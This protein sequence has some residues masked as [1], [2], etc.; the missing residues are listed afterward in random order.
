M[1]NKEFEFKGLKING[2]LM[3]FVVIA[4]FAM[5]IWGFV[6]FVNYGKSPNR[7]SEECNDYK[8]HQKSI[9][10]QSFKFKFLV[11]HSCIF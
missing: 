2:F 10:F 7:Q 6:E 8:Q 1:E 5:S 3:L 11:F 4:L 9:D